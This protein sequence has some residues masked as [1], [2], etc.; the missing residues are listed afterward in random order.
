LT[1]ARVRSV[2]RLFQVRQHADDFGGVR[3]DQNETVREKF[4]GEANKF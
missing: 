4:Q 2:I 3:V 1:P